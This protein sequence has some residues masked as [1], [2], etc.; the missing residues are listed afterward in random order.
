MKRRYLLL[1]MLFFSC[2]FFY[3]QREAA[4]WYFGN[5]AGINFDANN[6][7]TALTDG[8]LFTEEGCTSISDE[9]GNLLFYTNG[10][11]VYDRN[12]TPMPNGTD[13]NGNQSSTQSAIIIPKPQDAN[14][15]YIFTVDTQF[16]GDPDEGFQYSEVDMTLNGGLGDVTTVKNVVLLNNSSEKLSAVLKDCQ[17]EN[18]WVV[19][20]A[21]NIGGNLFNSIY[22]YEVTNTGVNTTPVVSTFS[23]GTSEQR[24]Y[25]KFSP[26]GEMLACANVNSGFFIADFN[27]DTG[28]ATF[29]QTINISA[30]SGGTFQSPY[31]LEFSP[32]NDYLYVTGFNAAATFN[33]ASGQRSSL[34]QYDLN[35]ANIPASE[36]VISQGTDY[37]SALQLGP[38]GKIY[39]TKSRHYDDG[40]PFLSVINNPNASGAACNFVDSAIDLNG[41][42]ARQGLPPFIASFF[43]EDIDII[44]TDN[45]STTILP[46]CT[47]DTYTLEAENIPG[48]SYTWYQDG[49][50]L[51]ETSNQLFI[52]EN[53]VYEVTIDLNSGDCEVKEGK[54]EVTYYEIPTATMPEN[55]FI[56]DDNNDDTFVFDLSTKDMEIL[57]GQN[58]VDFKVKYFENIND[59]NNNVNDLPVN[60]QNTSVQQTIYARVYNIN[61]ENCYALAQF[62]IGVYDTPIYNTVSNIISCDDLSDGNDANGQTTT[63]LTTLKSQIL[64]TQDPLEFDVT[65]HLSQDDADDNINQQ[66]ENFYNLTPFSLTLYVRIENVLNTNCYTTGNFVLTIN[67]VPTANDIVIKQCDE[68]GVPDGITQYNLNNA[69]DEITNNSTTS[70]I[71]FYANITDANSEEQPLDGD[72]YTNTTNNE[73]IYVVVTN[74][75]TT[76]KKTSEINLQI[77]ATS[78]N[79]YTAPE[80]C[81]ELDS[82]DGKNTFSLNSFSSII[83][84]GLP[85]GVTLNYYETFEDAALENNP[86]P[87]LWE[88]TIP[89]NQTIYGRAENGNE[90]FGINEIQLTINPRP[91]L[92]ND[93]LLFYCLNDFPQTSTLDSGLVGNPSDFSFSW[94]TGET[95][96]SIEINDVG[97]YTVT[98]TNNAS[99]CQ[100][101]RTF[102][103]EASNIATINQPI[104][105]NDGNNFQNVVEVTVTGEG[106]YEFAL[107]NDAGELIGFQDTGLFYYIPS[108]FYTVI[109]RDIK[110]NCGVTQ[111]DISVVGFPQYFTPNDDGVHDFWKADGINET[112]QPK[113]DI[114][115]FDRY[116]KLL[117]QIDPLG[118]GWDGTYNGQKMPTN[119]YWFK[120]ELQDGRI[121]TNNFTLK[122]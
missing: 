68:D 4:N 105:I 114:Y 23:F 122:R 78:I 102:T 85:G 74:P 56:C 96:P 101:T 49:N 48:A 100:S 27:L 83:L 26:S 47:G 108:G 52:D 113:S 110:N 31:G 2:T 25:L 28:V 6:N 13:L 16:G 44:P 94:T 120:V 12:H 57:N 43:S 51:A 10:T 24:G 8:T 119:D 98:V 107:Q 118:E 75:S 34:L 29:N 55:I 99:G 33:T 1:T 40:T 59:A 14:I 90:C 39:R 82:Q 93:E 72:N 54:A 61:N 9:S 15:Y 104:F 116:G 80:V 58:S 19:T 109:V 117:A 35:A 63:N 106:I 84:A 73:T 87:D 53:G 62:E 111:Q 69:Y 71:A 66:N 42:D 36:T 70:T 115:I 11:I 46:L 97:I 32:N 65:F 60:Y 37:R 81:D 89:Y 5:N 41:R 20:F 91:Q 121:Y 45:S 92:G 77:S 88:N 7:V 67:P 22:A 79:D 30:S 112:F 64:G 17:T 38:D 21:N 50:L 3:A 18:I 95:T 76:C 86:L 103:V